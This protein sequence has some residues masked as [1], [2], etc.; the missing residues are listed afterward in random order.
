MIVLR[1]S[2]Q[3]RW[4]RILW[5]CL[6]LVVL[7][8]TSVALFPSIQK[9]VNFEELTESLPAA[10]RSLLAFDDAVP[11]TSAPGYLQV[12]LFGSLVPVVL[13]VFAIEAGANAIG[14]SEEAGWL[15][16]TLMHPVTRVR[17]ALERYVAMFSLVFGLTAVLFT[18]LIAFSPPFG[19]LE[20]V[21][22]SGLAVASAAVGLLALLHG[23]FAFAIGAA[24]GRRAPAIGVTTAVAV[25]GYLING[26]G[27]I[28][29]VLRPLRPA[30]PWYWY[31]QRNMLAEGPQ[32]SGIALPLLLCPVLLFVGVKAFQRR[33]LA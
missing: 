4:P 33:D 10:F 21:S 6:G 18:S 30:S 5:W 25:A 8:V 27:A 1:R 9:E 28:S 16:L 32:F 19:A 20:G 24:T 3:D 12:R 31:L 15:E 26:L 29:D 17:V 11:L 2:I 7:V 22:M 13:L 14:G 23:T